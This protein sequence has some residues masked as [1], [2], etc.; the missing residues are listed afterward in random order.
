MP[1]TT[2]CVVTVGG[3]A[4]YRWCVR[5][6]RSRG[7]RARLGGTTQPLGFAMATWTSLFRFQPTSM[8]A[9]QSAAVSY[10]ARYSAKPRPSTPPSCGVWS[11]WS[12]A[13]GLDPLNL[14]QR[15][16]VELYIRHL[17]I[18]EEL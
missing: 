3:T 9:A 16:Q 10:L 1:P 14:I 17:A 15:A 8:S 6:L 18:G 13:N 11:R 5:K 7:R 2:R 4:I 12:Q